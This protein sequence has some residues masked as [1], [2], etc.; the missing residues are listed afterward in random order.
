MA[1]KCKALLGKAGCA[2][3]AHKQPLGVFVVYFFAFWGTLK[4]DL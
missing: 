1:R 3:L 4:I 2:V